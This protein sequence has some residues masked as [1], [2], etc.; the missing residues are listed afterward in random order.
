MKVEDRIVA[1]DPGLTTG[2]AYRMVLNEGEPPE[3]WTDE[4]KTL[5][6][7]LEQ[8]RE[9]QIQ[10]VVVERFATSGRI[11]RYGLETVEIVGALRGFAWCHNIQLVKQ[12]PQS[13]RSWI[14]DANAHPGASLHGRKKHEGRHE[15]DALAHL[16]QYV[17]FK[18][19][20]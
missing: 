17:Y 13:R 18:E 19:R 6:D 5:E 1:I 9:N 10:V 12:T 20:E 16:L 3:V 14:D 11:S 2:I 15:R 4:S 8:L 7:L